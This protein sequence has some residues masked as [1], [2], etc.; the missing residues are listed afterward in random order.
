MNEKNFHK[1]QKNIIKGDILLNQSLAQL[2]EFYLDLPFNR[3]LGLNCSLLNT[4]KA[5]LEF[6]K[7]PEFIGN[8]V[9]KI[10]HGGIITSALDASGGLLALANLYDRIQNEPLDEKIKLMGKSSTIDIRVDF[11]RPGLGS[12]FKIET[13]LLRSGTRIA[14][15]RMK[16]FNET[17]IIAAGSATYLLGC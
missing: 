9:K 14:V 4:E 8:T 11:L 5:L 1:F 7:K 16:L 12:D 15:T 10:L 2:K 6:K 3:F 17:E 13:E